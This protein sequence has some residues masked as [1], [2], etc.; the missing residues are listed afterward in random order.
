MSKVSL[1][2]ANGDVHGRVVETVEDLR[3]G[4][5]I[6]A[7]FMRICSQGWWVRREPGIS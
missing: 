4:D 6:R 1:A 5:D 2:T 7:K 3:H